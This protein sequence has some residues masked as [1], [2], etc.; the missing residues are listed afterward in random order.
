MKRKKKWSLSPES[1]ERHERVQAAL[2]ARIELLAKQDGKR[3][4]QQQS[5]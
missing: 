3:A 4:A 2:K 5:S 1:L